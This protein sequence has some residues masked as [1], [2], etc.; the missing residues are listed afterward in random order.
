[1]KKLPY[2]ILAILELMVTA[3]CNADKDNDNAKVWSKYEDWRNTNI[4]FFTSQ[5]RY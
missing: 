3:A 4:S 2:I 5:Q 1:M